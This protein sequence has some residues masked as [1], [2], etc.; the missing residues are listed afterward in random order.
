MKYEIRVC[1]KIFTEENIFQEDVKGHKIPEESANSFL[2]K[3]Q[4][5]Q[6]KNKEPGEN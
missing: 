4:S 3:R 5:G 6:I 1:Y 2:E